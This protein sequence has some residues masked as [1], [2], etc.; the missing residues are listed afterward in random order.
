MDTYYIH[1]TKILC[2]KSQDTLH[3]DVFAIGQYVT[4]IYK[5]GIQ[6]LR[7]EMFL[8]VLTLNY[9]S[10]VTFSLSC[11]SVSQMVWISSMAKSRMPG[12]WWNSSS[13]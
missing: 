5:A 1:F 13:L 3:Y 10:V 2:T 11:L 4:G 8:Y 6:E 7:V 12:S 9:R